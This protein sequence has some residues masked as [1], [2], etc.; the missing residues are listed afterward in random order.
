MKTLALVRSLLLAAA[1][2]AIGNMTPALY[3][4]TTEEQAVLAPVQAMFD[5]M[6]KRDAAAIK[7]PLLHDGTMVVMRKGNLTQMTLEAF[8]DR[9]QTSGKTHIE[10]RIHDPPNPNR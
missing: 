10:E 1:T 4:T 2:A 3:A 5:G 7:E 8:A 6:A 9:V